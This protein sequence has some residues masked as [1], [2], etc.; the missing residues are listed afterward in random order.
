MLAPKG[1]PHA[2]GNARKGEPAR[3]RLVMTLRIRALVR[4]LHEPVA[5]DYA[6]I[7]RAHEPELL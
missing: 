1:T 7:F 3:Y 2:Y 4:A 6:S 5:D